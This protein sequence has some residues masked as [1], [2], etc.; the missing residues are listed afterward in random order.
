MAF[1]VRELGRRV[2][3][4][5]FPRGLRNRV[6]LAFGLLALALSLVL[7]LLAWAFV[8]GRLVGDLQDG[9]VR[10]TTVDAA[11][12]TPA[13][14]QD[15]TQIP[16]LLD[17]LPATGA[18]S[19]LLSSGARW[20]STSPTLGPTTVPSRLIA[21]VE[22]GNT[23]RQRVEVDGR[24]YLVVGVPLSATVGGA[25]YEVF[26]LADLDSTLHV[27]SVTLVGVAVLTAIL[28]LAMGR[29]ASRLALR[30]LAT[31]NA[32]ASAVARGEVGAR[33]SARGDPGL[34]ALA[35]SFNRTAEA[36][37]QRVTADARFAGDVS[38]ELRTPLTT[39]LNSMQVV[40]NRE[41]DLPAAVREPIDLL[42]DELERFRH[43]V[44]DLLE[45]SRQD[46]GERPVLETVQL[47]E[48]VR[49][50]A[51]AAAGRPVTEVAPEAERLSCQVD[52]RRLERVVA[53]LVTNAATHGGGCVRVGVVMAVDGG[54]RIEVDDAGP[55]IA[56]DRRD[57]V[58]ERFARG[59]PVS[60]P[61]VGLGL[62]IVARHVRLH[63]GTVWV[64]DRPGGGARFVVRLPVGEAW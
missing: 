56:P 35:S 23:A 29:V 43:L 2:G 19:V 47:G 10:A 32:A 41:S 40:R 57:R 60:S 21:A 58:F 50:A 62:S 53:N 48:L 34:E 61:G 64:E 5:V 11:A 45:I 3:G 38:H 14:A 51:D 33:L 31:F 15:R 30:P 39:M 7:S 4:S 24:R 12:I 37:E 27:L 55:G 26:S 8:S 49:H 36:L 16:V 9:A 17:G 13:M 25:Y 42:Q 6:T 52:K 28:G 44:V 20:Y 63:G 46:G 18:V 1:V 54:V 59:G 22:D